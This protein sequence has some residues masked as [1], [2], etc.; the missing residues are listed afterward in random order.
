MKL[1]V[2]VTKDDYQEF[3]K[4]AYNRLLGNNITTKRNMLTNMV[5]WFVIALMFLSI[6]NV[7]STNF[8][9]FHL[10][11]ALIAATPLL[12]FIGYMIFFT[13]K[14]QKLAIPKEHGLLLGSKEI[15]INNTGITETNDFGT[16]YYKWASVESIEEVNG[17]VYLF[18]DKMLG[19]IFPVSCFKN[20]DER[21]ELIEIINQKI[22]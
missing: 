7:L 14:A 19:Y 15:E 18:F 4:Y 1:K 10:N 3:I 9:S 17:N 16:A 13:K 12:I 22:A 21:I 8:K 5:I 6:F 11:S 20:D 2:H